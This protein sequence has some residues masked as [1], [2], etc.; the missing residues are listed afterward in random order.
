M[1][2]TRK[3]ALETRGAILDAAESVFHRQGVARTTLAEIASEANVTRGAIYWHFAGKADLFESMNDRVVLPEEAF[4][5]RRAEGES[6]DTLDGLKSLMLEMVRRF[7]ADAH[8]QRVHDILLFRCEYVG[9][10][11]DAMRRR[12]EIEDAFSVALLDAFG[13]VREGRGLGVGWTPETA[14]NGLRCVV[15]GVMSDWIRRDRS[16]DVTA[17]ASAVLDSLF[18]SF[19]GDRTDETPA[20]TSEP[21]EGPHAKRPA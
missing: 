15:M 11:S 18:A 1:R 13:R 21:G 6:G 17:V 16:F 19:G 2:R 4:F 20:S 7:A 5:R 12:R 9:E 10:M 14:A 3:E 8:A